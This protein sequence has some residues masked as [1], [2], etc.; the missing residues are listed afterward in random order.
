MATLTPI[1][2]K[3]LFAPIFRR[4]IEQ[5]V[6]RY[7]HVSNFALMVLVISAFIS[8]AA[9]IGTTV[10]FGAFLSG[11]FLTYLP[12]K[13]PESPFVVRSRKAGER[14][15]GKTPTFLHTFEWCL[16]DTQR[17]LLEPLFFAS[18]GF[19]IPFVKLWI[20]V[21]VWRGVVYT[22]LMTFAKVG[23]SQTINGCRSTLLNEIQVIVGAWVP[24]WNLY[25]RGGLQKPMSLLKDLMRMNPRVEKSM[26]LILVRRVWPGYSLD[27]R[28]WREVKSG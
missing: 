20:G 14:E 5:P 21:R 3:Y 4:Y 23:L 11:T 19:A 24:L 18:I 13:K 28:W 17:Y 9:Y 26:N 22:L 12:S 16:L 15:P 25:E 7:H 1:L 10:L 8:I 6:S 2:T 27:R